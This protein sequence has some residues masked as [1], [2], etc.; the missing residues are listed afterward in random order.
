MSE[1]G[2][3]TTALAAR[4]VG[5]V[6]R[7]ATRLGFSGVGIADPAAIE[8]AGRDLARFVEEGRHGEMAWMAET[9]DRRADPRTLWR[10]VRSILVFAFD[11]GPKTNPLE[12]PRGDGRGEISAYARNRDYHEL[13]KGRLK[14]I[15][16]KLAA[17]ARRTGV[18]CD[19]KVFVDTAPVMEKPLAQAA[20]LAWVAK[21]TLAISRKIGGWFFLGTI[22]TTLDLPTSEPETSHCGS[23]NRCLDVCPTAAITAPHQIDARRC[24]SYL[25][26]EHA[27]AIPREFRA[28]MGDRIYGC[29]DCLAVCPWNR[30][31]EA[32]REAKL[33]A[34]A[35]LVRPR[36]AD[37]V[38][39]DDA[40]FRALFAG[41]PVKRI[42]RDRFLRN[43]LIAIGNSSDASLE[44]AVRR[45]LDE[46][47]AVVRGAAAWALG[48]LTPEGFA[49]EAARRAA[50]ERDGDVA[51]EWTA[52]AI[53]GQTGS[54][55][56][57]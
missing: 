43:V 33:I 23:C 3:P 44:G 16:G 53:V 22:F 25:T 42:G 18:A 12:G 30:F 49:K 57:G 55:G 8:A 15:G 17:E 6:E 36:L 24:L 26:I 11:Y 37:L 40:A 31:A 41:S 29:D 38:E 4:L 32:A 9:L 5:L 48:R 13:I 28:A 2:A 54:G 45:R 46:P 34:R 10:E 56:T 47:A 7:E 39:L 21:S 1:G 27:G 20:G 52:S 51:A 50:A 35:E 14:E 19:L